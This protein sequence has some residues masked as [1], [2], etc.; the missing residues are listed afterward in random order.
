MK[1]GFFYVHALSALHVGTGQGAGVIDLPIAR[2]RATQLP[3][4]PGS[5]IKGVLRQDLRQRVGEHWETLFG[6]ASVHDDTGFAG[7]LALGDA[8]LLC[9]PVR[10]LCGTFAWATSPFVLS[11]YARESRAAG[12]DDLPPVPVGEEAQVT[13]DSSLVIRE[14]VVLEDLDVRA[15][16]GADAWAEHLSMRIFSDAEWQ[17]LFVQRFA[18]LPDEAFGFLA[19]T[20]TEVRARVRIDDETRTVAKGALWYEENLPAETILFGALGVDRARRGGLNQ[21]AETLYGVLPA[22]PLRMQLGG[23][24]SVGRGWAH[25]RLREA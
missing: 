21:S 3:F 10:S 16:P 8:H 7:A 13:R 18:I 6:P 5:A 11:R 1:S 23:K 17:R 9:L 19:E 20:A 24:A 14:S 2:E 15:R 4:V 12:F 22:G 25:W